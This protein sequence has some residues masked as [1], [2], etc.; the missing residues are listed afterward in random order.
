M[1]EGKFFGG[2]A[3]LLCITS[4]MLSLVVRIY[5]AVY[6]V[7]FFVRNNRRLNVIFL[8]DQSYTQF[9]GLSTFDDKMFL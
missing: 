2:G 1:R 9:C 3:S 7:H 5:V 8:D 4:G 6:H